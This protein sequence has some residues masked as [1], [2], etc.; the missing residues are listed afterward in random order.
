MSHCVWVIEYYVS[1]DAD[2]TIIKTSYLLLRLTVL[3][4]HLKKVLVKLAHP[5][6]QNQI[7]NSIIADITTFIHSKTTT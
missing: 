1:V 4:S 5:P 2:Q 3:W 6:T 7:F